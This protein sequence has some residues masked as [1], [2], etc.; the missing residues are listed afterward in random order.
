MAK[1]QP[2]T[3]IDFVVSAFFLWFRE[4][5]PNIAEVLIRSSWLTG[6]LNFTINVFLSKD[7]IITNNNN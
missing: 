6:I 2:V 3:L 4:A 7:I 1:L 5:Q